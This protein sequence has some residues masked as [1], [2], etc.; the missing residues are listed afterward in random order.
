VFFKNDTL[1]FFAERCFLDVRDY[2]YNLK[3][4][5]G[6]TRVTFSTTPENYSM[7]ETFETGDDNGFQDL[8][9]FTNTNANTT[10]ED[11]NQLP[12]DEVELLQSGQT[13]A[14]V[15]IGMNKGD[16]VDLSVQ[17]NY[18]VAPSGNSFLGTAF[19][20]LFSSFDN[21]YGSGAGEAGVSSAPTD[22]ENALTG[23][24]MTG[25]GNSSTAPRAF[26]N[27]LLFDKSM[28]YI[29]A[30]FV[31]LTTAAQGVGVH[32][33]LFVDDIVA[34][35]EGYVLAYL[36]NENTE[37]VNVHFDDFTIYHGKTNV[38][39]SDD[40]Y[41]FGLTFNS[42]SRTASTPQNF[43]YNG[44]EL[45]EET[46]WLDY[47]RRMYQPE[48][49]RFF[50]QDRYSE[51]YTDLT[52][53]HYT[54]N[55][56]IM[57]MDMNG[58]SLILSDAFKN[59][60][61]AMMAFD[62]FSSSD[63]GKALNR[64]YGEDGKYGTTNVVFDLVDI[65]YAKG[66]TRT[67]ATNEDGES[68]ELRSEN[69]IAKM[70]EMGV[71]T[72]GMRSAPKDGEVVSHSIVINEPG[73]HPDLNETSSSNLA[74]T[75]VHEAQHVKINDSQIRQKGKL[76]LG[77]GQT[78]KMMRTNQGMLMERVNAARQIDPRLSNKSVKELMKVV[79]SFEN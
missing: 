18:E 9:R 24:G 46:G 21:I 58:D 57:Y 15:F 56:P 2:Q 6:N 38:V 23:A 72:N 14:M 67:E 65:G 62:K 16:T 78:H 61:V 22:F 74:N 4:H 76:I 53:Y 1:A 52:P 66:E 41:P 63:A 19:G 75:F 44:K 34:E 17:A 50:N 31:Q 54:A 79:N 70:D 51:K 77:A 47:G 12:G 29:S 30:G 69:D 71:N 43:K 10:I 7:V 45:Q 13:G 28:N 5:L 3:D 25:K 26:L 60:E 49:G 20:T 8:H 59:N 73:S 42:Y 32:E 39:Q 33:T 37:A 36:S 68:T 35:Q 11:S 64:L 55:N 48:I 27:Y 40:Y